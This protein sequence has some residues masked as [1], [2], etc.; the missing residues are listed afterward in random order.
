MLWGE[1][2]PAF[3]RQYVV[4]SRRVTGGDAFLLT[5]QSDGGRVL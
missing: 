4:G 2:H 3:L 1:L 5:V